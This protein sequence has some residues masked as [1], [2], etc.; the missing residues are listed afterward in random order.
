MKNSKIRRMLM[1]GIGIMFFTLSCTNLDEKLYDTV[2]ADNFFKTDEE[3]VAAL[4]QAYSSFGGIGNHFGLW[5]INE[6]ASDEVVICTKGGDWY[7]GGVLLQLHRHEFA[8]GNGMFN[9]AWGFVFGGINT[10]NRL[11]YQFTA[12]NTPAA[13]AFIAELR[14]VRALWYYWALDAWGNVPL[15]TDFANLDKPATTPRAQIYAFVERN[16]LTLSLFFLQRRMLLPM[17]G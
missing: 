3:F 12:L 8:A 17:E 9:S 2:T 4:G 11:I 15:V 1:T 6:L 5:T 7:D 10:C 13:A 16:C 14:A